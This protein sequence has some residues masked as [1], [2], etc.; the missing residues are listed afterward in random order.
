MI[1]NALRMN[2]YL[3]ISTQPRSLK[4]NSNI[5][6]AHSRCTCL[7]RKAGTEKILPKDEII[8]PISQPKISL[9]STSLISDYYKTYLNST[10][11]IGRKKKTYGL[12]PLPSLAI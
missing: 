9:E 8:D 3:Y 1:E 7:E 4:Y 10:K 5:R 12:M 6:K 11:I 2:L